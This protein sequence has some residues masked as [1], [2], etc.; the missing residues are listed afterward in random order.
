MSTIEDILAQIDYLPPFP[1][2]VTRVL[3][4]LRDPDVSAEAI[5]DAVKFDQGLTTNILRVCNSSYYGLR[6]TVNSLREAVVYIGL[7][8]LKKMIVRSGTRQYFEKKKPGYESKKGELWVHVL[9]V[10]IVSEKVASLIDSTG[11]DNVFIA[12]LLHDIGKLVLSEFVMDTSQKIFDLIDGEGISFLE[13]EQRILGVGHDEIGARVLEKWEFPDEVISAVRK[14]HSP[15]DEEDTALDNIVRLSDS[16]AMIMG[17]G[18]SVD[19]L[20]YPGFSD[21]T[22]KYELKQED[23]QEVMAVT[24]DEITKLEAEYGFTGEE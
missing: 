16:L 12:S 22:R 23:L 24:V 17:F 21:L 9:A 7:T 8:E 3:K 1:V 4:M 11:K 10:S 6:R 15:V 2:T 18:T 20:A 14:H 19:G 5:A 13:A